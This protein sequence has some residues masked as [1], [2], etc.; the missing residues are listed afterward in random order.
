MKVGQLL[1]LLPLQKAAIL[2]VGF[3]SCTLLEA[4]LGIFEQLQIIK[5]E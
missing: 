4:I 3:D 5:N 2:C 1:L